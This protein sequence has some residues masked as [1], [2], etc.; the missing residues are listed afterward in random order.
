MVIGSARLL[1]L[2]THDLQ[3][4]LAYLN[5]EPVADQRSVM[6]DAD[7]AVVNAHADL[8][9]TLLS[10]VWPPNVTPP[11]PNYV[12]GRRDAPPRKDHNR[13]AQIHRW[14]RRCL[15]FGQQFFVRGVTLPNG[16]IVCDT[17]EQ[18]AHL[19]LHWQH[20]FQRAAPTP[21]L[22]DAFARSFTA[23]LDTNGIDPP[24]AHTMAQYIKRVRRSASG[25]DGFP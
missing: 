17:G 7:T 12:A 19:A 5:D 23:P 18:E 21:R 13:A 25:P 9:A 1:N 2:A 24:C 22:G 15:P 10:N 6:P 8:P 16:D 14:L 20:L 11:A 3:T 4:Q